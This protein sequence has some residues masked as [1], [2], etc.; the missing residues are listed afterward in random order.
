MVSN[1][2]SN[3]SNENINVKKCSIITLGFICEKLAANKLKPDADDTEKILAGVAC[4]LIEEQGNNDLRV[5][6]LKAVQDMIPFFK[7][8][9][10]EETTRDFFLTLI[11]KHAKME[12]EEVVLKAIQCLIDIFRNCYE[13]LSERYMNVILDITTSLMRNSVESIVIATTEFWDSVAKF[14]GELV[15]RTG[16][17]PNLTCLNFVFNYSNQLTQVL[18]ENLLKKDNEELESGLSIHSVTMDCLSKVNSLGFKTN[19]DLNISFIS[20][21]IVSE[22][23]LN[24]V[25]ALQCFEAMIIGAP[26]DISKLIESSLTTILQLLLVNEKLCIASLKVI[27]AVAIN[28][29]S[30][31]LHEQICPKWL[32][33]TAKLLQNDLK[34]APDICKIYAECG[35]SLYGSSPGSNSYFMTKSLDL[36]QGLLEICFTKLSQSELYIASDIFIARMSIAKSLDTLERLG[37]FMDFSSKCL[38]NV[39]RLPGELKSA[40]KEGLFIDLMVGFVYSD[41]LADHEEGWGHPRQTQP[42]DSRRNIRVRTQRMHQRVKRFLF[43]IARSRFDRT[44]YCFVIQLSAKSFRPIRFSNCVHWHPTR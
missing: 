12:N 44:T 32:E 3:A 43:R 42:R 1:L 27:S 33:L 23:D 24:K 41:R 20:N 21:Q 25:A 34:Y 29:T 5:T 28:Y 19:K 17:G 38:F 37:E 11:L 16:G 10:R 8:Q 7:D 6:S 9:L 15:F 30:I 18:L 2:S 40:V 14:E 31:L 35:N 13:Y 39:Q 36:C 22:R 26:E 4:G